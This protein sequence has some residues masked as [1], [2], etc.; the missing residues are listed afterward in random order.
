M[1]SIRNISIVGYKND[2]KFVVEDEDIKINIRKP[3]VTDFPI[4]L[5]IGLYLLVG[6]HAELSLI[7]SLSA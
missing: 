3:I 5:K 7:D 6:R 4:C 1:T 2:V